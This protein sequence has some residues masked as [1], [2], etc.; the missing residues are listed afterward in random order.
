MKG[1]MRQALWAVV[2]A[3]LAVVPLAMAVMADGDPGGGP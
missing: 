1:R 2:G 3:L